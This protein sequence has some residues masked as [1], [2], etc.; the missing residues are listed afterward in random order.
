MS[1]DCDEANVVDC[2]GLWMIRRPSDDGATFNCIKK[3]EVIDGMY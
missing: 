2:K 3:V 1:N